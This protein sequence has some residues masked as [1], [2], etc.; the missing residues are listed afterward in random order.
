MNQCMLP[1]LL[2]FINYHYRSAKRIKLQIGVFFTPRSTSYRVKTQNK[3]TLRPLGEERMSFRTKVM[4]PS[5]DISEH[6][7]PDLENA[8]GR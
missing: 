1:V 5:Q 8:K 4:E 7:V 6:F 2:K 3:I